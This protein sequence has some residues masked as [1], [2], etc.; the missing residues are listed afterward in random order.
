[1]QEGSKCVMLVL[2]CSRGGTR[3][4]QADFS[5]EIV[6]EDKQ[7]DHYLGNSVHAPKGRWAEGRDILWYNRGHK[8]KEDSE[9]RKKER[10]DV[11]QAEREAME[12]MLYVRTLTL[13]DKSGRMKSLPKMAPLGKGAR[14]SQ[15]GQGPM[16]RQ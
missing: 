5:W 6:R 11:K 14:V 15:H 8:D 2:T 9:S 3:G 16:L 1:M 4:G 10:M 7:R 13:G 12:Q